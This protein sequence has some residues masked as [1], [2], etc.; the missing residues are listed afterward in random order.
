MVGLPVVGLETGELLPVVTH[1]TDNDG[2]FRSSGF[3]AFIEFHPRTVPCS[4]P[5]QAPG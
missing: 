5:G 2:P 4:D 3:E 1:L